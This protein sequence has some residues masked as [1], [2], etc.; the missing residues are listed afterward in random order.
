MEIVLTN[1]LE[2]LQLTANNQAITDGYK[3]SGALHY[4]EYSAFRATRTGSGISAQLQVVVS[5]GRRPGC[6]QREQ[7]RYDGAARPL[8]WQRP[9]AAPLPS[10]SCRACC[11]R[12]PNVLVKGVRQLASTRGANQAKQ[13]ACRRNM[14]Q[15]ILSGGERSTL[16][17]S[18]GIILRR[19]TLVAKRRCGFD[20]E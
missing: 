14:V 2:E 20:C 4:W 8:F 5:V 7:G 1:E 19:R 11:N 15:L 9:Q 13:R 17:P 16:E 6:G 12:G 18:S 3:G 10:E